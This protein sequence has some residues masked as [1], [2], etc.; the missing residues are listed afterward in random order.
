[1]TTS[2]QAPNRH[3]SAVRGRFAWHELMTTELEAA[4]QFYTSVIGWGTQDWPASNPPYT[5]WT[6]Q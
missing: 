6:A 4:R 1:M 5:M 2:A 3:I